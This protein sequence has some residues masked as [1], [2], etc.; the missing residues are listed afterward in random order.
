VFTPTYNQNYLV[1]Q[2]YTL[3]FYVT[4]DPYTELEVYM[5]SD[6][7]NQSV[8][9]PIS[10]PRAF[11]KTYNNE[12]YRYKDTYNR[13]GKYVGKIINDR[14]VRKYYGKVMFDFETDANGLGSPLFRSRIVDEQSGVT[15]SAYISE[16]SIKPFQLN[17]FSP[18]LL[19]FPVQLSTEVAEAMTVSQSIDFK[20]EY[21]DYTGRQSEY[22]TYLDD[23]VVNFQA[24]IPGNGCQAENTAFEFSNAVTTSRRRFV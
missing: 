6:D 4:L 18:K 23:V 17:G 8:I 2:L 24:E 12:K 14:P 9:T 5:N 21:Y 15:G 11:F 3:S 7:L 16:V 19:Q 10:Y 1:D 22:V 13:F 20:I